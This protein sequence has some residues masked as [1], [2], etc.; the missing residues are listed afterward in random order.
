M[1]N[2]KKSGS[3]V[4][5]TLVLS[6]LA[7][8]FVATTATACSSGDDGRS[9]DG[10]EQFVNNDVDGDWTNWTLSGTAFSWPE[11]M[12][13]AEE[14]EFSFAFLPSSKSAL[15]AACSSG[16][17]LKQRITSPHMAA[18][19]CYAVLCS[20]RNNPSATR[21]MY[22]WLKGPEGITTV[23]WQNISRRLK[24]KPYITFA[25]FE[26]ATP[27]NNYTPTTPFVTKPYTQ[28]QGSTS[29][30]VYT[31]RGTYT[32]VDGVVYC[33][34]FVRS[35]GADRAVPIMTKFHRASG[36]WFINGSAMV[37]LTDIRTPSSQGGG[38]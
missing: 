6:L 12:R 21:E 10:E 37:A 28:A 19:L 1:N 9:H 27:L 7:I 4:F 30:G 38:Y 17:G 2:I 16:D 20:Y 32:E 23:E 36:N 14:K 29:G 35:G 26:G 11:A 33:K 34:V 22:R 15:M 25:F 13:L 18:A 8:L 24:E 3:N 5:A 31:D